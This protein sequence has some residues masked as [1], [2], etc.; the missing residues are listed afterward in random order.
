MP[1]QWNWI[2]RA[3]MSAPSTYPSFSLSTLQLHNTSLFKWEKWEYVYTYFWFNVKIN[4]SGL[5]FG[6]KTLACSLCTLQSHMRSL[7]SATYVSAPWHYQESLQLNKLVRQ[8]Q[9]SDSSSLRVALGKTLSP[10]HSH[11]LFLLCP[12]TDRHL[13]SFVSLS[14]IARCHS[15]KREPEG[16]L[17]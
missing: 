9:Q 3:L 6:W 12:P 16:G 13:S 15:R 2:K 5:H 4:L 17:E 7:C 10:P 11:P 1:A 8:P 14:L